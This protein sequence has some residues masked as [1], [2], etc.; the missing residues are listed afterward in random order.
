MPKRGDRTAVMNNFSEQVAYS[1]ACEAKVQQSDKESN[2]MLDMFSH[3][4]SYSTFVW[5]VLYVTVN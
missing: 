4:L 5:S 3:S 1:L 2:I